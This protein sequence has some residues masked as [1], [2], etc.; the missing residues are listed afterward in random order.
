MPNLV[1]RINALEKRIPEKRVILMSW[2]REEGKEA[3]QVS[4]G[5]EKWTRSDSETE[6][7]FLSR[8]RQE[9]DYPAFI[10]LMTESR[11]NRFLAG[12]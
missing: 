3:T 8:V 9:M 1:S 4:S 10:K 6:D 12:G 2:M 11:Y 7:E 5:S